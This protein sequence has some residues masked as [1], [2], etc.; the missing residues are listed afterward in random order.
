[1]KTYKA[2]GSHCEVLIL[3][4]KR[5]KAYKVKAKTESGK[6]LAVLRSKNCLVYIPTKNTVT[7][8]PFFKL[9]EPKNPL[10]LR[11]VSKLTEIRPLNNVSVTQDSTGERISLDLLEIDDNDIGFPKLVEFLVLRPFRP[12]ELL[13]PG[14]PEPIAIGPLKPPKPKNK[15]AEELMKPVDSSNLDEIQLNLITS[16]CYRVKVKIFKKKL[17]KNSF[18]PNTYKQTLKNPNVKEWLA[19]TFNEFEQLINLETFK[20]LPYE[21]LSKDRK[22]LTNRLVF[23]EKKD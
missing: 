15:P 12:L 21:A 20:F 1:M 6:L 5:P 23:K 22:L 18:T 17:D 2:I 11:G 16:F 19:V 9:Y 10:L 8:T 4:E 14:P 13:I 7:K 3:L